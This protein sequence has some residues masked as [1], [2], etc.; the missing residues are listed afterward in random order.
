M[1][2]V[3]KAK[4]RGELPLGDRKTA[5]QRKRNTRKREEM[6]GVTPDE[7]MLSSLSSNFKR[8][9]QQSHYSRFSLKIVTTPTLLALSRGLVLPLYTRTSNIFRTPHK[10][11]LMYTPLGHRGEFHQYVAQH[12]VVAI[13][14]PSSNERK[15]NNKQDNNNEKFH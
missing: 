11:S 7:F 3:D 5:K 12:I 14:T 15:Y 8:A 1:H 6:P 2:G 10:A 4:G 13:L 9:T